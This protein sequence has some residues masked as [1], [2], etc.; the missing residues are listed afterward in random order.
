MKT[1]ECAVMG[2]GDRGYKAYGAVAARR[3]DKIRFVAVAESHAERRRRFAQKFKIPAE[4]CFNDWRELLA[5]PQIAPAL[6]VTL[7][8]SLHLE[9]T[10]QALAKGYHV[11]LEKP[12]AATARDCIALVQAAARHRRVLQVCHV[13][14]YSRLFSRIKDLLDQGSLG[15]L[16]CIQH[17]E[18]IGFWHMAHS[19]VRGNWRKT[20]ES[21]PLIL[22][23]SCHDT[24][25]LTWFAG[26][27]ALRVSSF[28]S[29]VHFRPE[30]APAGAPERCTDN[31]PHEKTCPYSAIR[32]YLD[33]GRIKPPLS[34]L[35][36]FSSQ[37]IWDYLK[38]PRAG[39]FTSKITMDLSREGILKAL[40]EGPYG[41]CVYRCDNDVCD[42]QVVIIEFAGGVK[43]SFVL[44]AFTAMWERTLKLMG[45]KGE[46]RAADLK[47]R[48]ELRT[49][50][51]LK[52]RRRRIGFDAFSHGRGDEGV[53]L[54]FARAVQTGAAGEAL[55]SARNSLESHLIAFAA[56]ESRL[57]G[58]TVEME[59]FRRRMGL[60]VS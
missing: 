9:P 35:T 16:T 54:D 34:L 45:A 26:T 56:E 8:D 12:M 39:S 11:L 15:D 57:T 36:G 4:N 48:L 29:L 3:P 19:Y 47:G 43:A 28:G 52:V 18:N 38:N 41:R 51:P 21:S 49:F 55:T 14:R 17:N 33:P 20:A 13:L 1:L 42:H 50:H 44:S 32:F 23:K 5:G 59:E 58:R 27:P 30:N 40:R 6:L 60:A 37:T 31:C 10:L 53:L 46:I 24:D 7:Q 25:L 22:A 2:A